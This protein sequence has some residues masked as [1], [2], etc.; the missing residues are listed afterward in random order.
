MYIALE[1]INFTWEHSE[2]RTFCK[3]WR[4]GHSLENIA[5]YL[6]RDMDEV[7]VLLMDQIRENKIKPRPHGIA[8]CF[9]S[10]EKQKKLQQLTKEKYLQMKNDEL[11]DTQIQAVYGL[12]RYY[13]NKLKKE[14]GLVG[15]K[16]KNRGYKE[17][18]RVV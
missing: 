3:L 10:E 4:A 7:A 9:T 16:V 1:E 5:K 8:E 13:L 15:E 6:K 2:V 14:W 18:R 12:T 17:K 11:E